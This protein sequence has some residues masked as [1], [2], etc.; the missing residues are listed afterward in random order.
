[1]NKTQANPQ[2][3]LPFTHLAALIGGDLLVI[4]SFIWI[5]R[6]SHSL[7]TSD[8]LAGLSTALPFIIGWFLITPWFG[9]YKGNVCQNRRRLIPRLLIAWAIAVP[10][11]LGLR[12]LFLGRPIPS[13]ILPFF[14]AISMAYIGLVMLIWRLGYVWWVNRRSTKRNAGV[15]GV[16]L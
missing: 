5:G 11:G 12:A 4:L 10:V 3:H 8:I 13:G 7:S 9:I 14:A 15:S 2:G 1:M 6:S 16:E